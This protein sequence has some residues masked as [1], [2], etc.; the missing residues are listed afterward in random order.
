[1]NRRS[2]LLLPSLTFCLLVAIGVAGRWGQPAWGATPITAVALVAG[3]Y[4]THRGVAMLVPFASLFLS[5]LLLQA[6]DNG[7]VMFAVYGC[8]MATA[9]L[10]PLLRDGTSTGVKRFARFALCGTAPATWFFV[11]TNFAVWMFRSDYTK[12]IS[13]LTECYIAALPFYRNMLAGDVFYL[14]LMVLAFSL[15]GAGLTAGRSTAGRVTA[16]QRQI[17]AS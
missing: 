10:G 17:A 16:G 4:F 12:T 15:A 8:M 3:A 9:L 11:V 2:D 7:P 6:H 14:G 5:D 13:G 1:M